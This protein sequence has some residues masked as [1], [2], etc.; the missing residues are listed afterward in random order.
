MGRVVALFAIATSL[1]AGGVATAVPASAATC[2]GDLAIIYTGNVPTRPYLVEVYGRTSGNYYNPYETR[3][4]VRLWGEDT[5]YDNLR[6]GPVTQ[7]ITFNGTE[8]YTE[9]TVSG[10]TLNEDYGDRDEIYAG[11]RIIDSQTGRV[12]EGIETYRVNGWFS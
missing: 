11:I 9:F 3:I 6:H 4:E 8:V 7:N 10:A 5:W 2:C 1:V 12:L